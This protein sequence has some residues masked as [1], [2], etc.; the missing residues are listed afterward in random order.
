[1]S[2]KSILMD[3][4][5]A[6]FNNSKIYESELYLK[7]L[8]NTEQLEQKLMDKFTEEDLIKYRETRMDFELL[9]Y[10][11]GFIEGI[12]FLNEIIRSQPNTDI[13]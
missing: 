7:I 5:T 3:L 4:F 12:K 8:K 9:F 2:T 6:S 13:Y 11:Y 1:M 10:E